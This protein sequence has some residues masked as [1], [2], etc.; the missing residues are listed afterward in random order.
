[1]KEG[2]KVKRGEKEEGFL[3][4]HDIVNTARHRQYG[5]GKKEERGG[6]E[7]REGGGG[8]CID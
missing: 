7:R 3:R 8:E 5:G 2:K 6:G 4:Y 1:M